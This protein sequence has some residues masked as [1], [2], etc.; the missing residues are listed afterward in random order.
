M[1]SLP[2]KIVSLFGLILGAVSVTASPLRLDY[3]IT[4]LGGSLYDY[5]FI[6]SV[7]DH[8]GSFQVG[9]GW[10]WI[11]FG[12]V[13]AAPSNLTNFVFDA[14]DFPV[15]PFLSGSSSSGGHNGPTLLEFDFSSAG[16]WHPTA[17]GDSLAWSG[18]SDAYLGQGELKFSTLNFSGPGT[19][20]ADFE[21]ANLVHAQGPAV[22]EEVSVLPLLGIA[23]AAIAGA[24]RLVAGSRQR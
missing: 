13:L 16:G 7:D 22:P 3:S 18:T 9:Q 24:R 23:L 10:N 5:D 20:Y 1:K 12:D 11:T 4:D 14:S 8:D 21:T 6:L 2:S 19:T 17:V 15:G